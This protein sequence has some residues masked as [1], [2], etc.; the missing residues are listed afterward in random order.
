KI[1]G[2]PALT[3]NHT[4]VQVSRLKN[5][6]KQQRPRIKCHPVGDGADVDTAEVVNGL[7]RHIETLSD[8]S[9]AYDVGVSSA[10][11]IGWGY[12]RILSEYIS[13]TSF[14]Q[15]LKIAPIRNPFTVYMDPTAKHPA[16]LDQGWCII[17]ETMKR[18][19]YKRKYPRAENS[20]WRYVDAPGDMTLDWESKEE[21]RLAEYY[22]IHEVRDTLCQL[23]DGATKYKSEL[24]SPEV[25][26][27]AGVKVVNERPTTRCVVQWFRLNGKAIVDKRDLPGYHIPVVRCEGNVLD[28]NGRVRRK[29]MVYDLMDPARIYNYTETQKTERYALTPKAPWVGFEGQFDGHPEWVD[30]NQKSYSTLVHKPVQLPDGSIAPPPQRTPPAAVEAGMAEWSASAERNL[31]SVAGMPQENPEI[32]A[33]V[34]GGNKYLQ[35]RQGMQDLVHFQYYDNQTLAIASTGVLLLELIPFYYDTPRMQRIIREDG[36]PEMVKLK[37]TYEEDGVQKVKNDPTV[38]RYDVVMDTGPGYA[39]KRE[40]AA[41]SMLEL[42]NTKLGEKVAD[43]S[44]D[45]V[46]RNMD[47]PGSSEVADR[48]AT[49]IPGALD[50]IVENLPKQA[51]TIVGSL[52]AQ[53][54]QAGDMIQKLQMEIKYKSGVETMK[55]QGQTHRTEIQATTQL[56]KT[57][58]EVKAEDANSERDYVGWMRDVKERGDAQ[59]DVAE[60]HAAAQLLNTH[61]EAAHE[62]K[63]ADKLIKAGTERRE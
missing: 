57:A 21:I 34:V 14:D 11:D 55:D 13:P 53:L 32:S 37:Q 56:H 12:W 9:V 31:M 43:T 10:V 5:T 27:A 3:I 4:N 7:I 48:V 40:E 60:I 24:Y 39:T 38:G 33:K 51:Q 36:V 8:A 47:F 22:R 15:E 50:K 62:A 28:M 49:T 20:D 2:R 18:A 30:A 63:A 61:V 1:E 41:E 23:S 26:A 6:L 25:M 19:E 42:L 17:S 16:G 52:Q 46:L 54:K 59:R 58:M 29:G 35:R 45:I 44:G